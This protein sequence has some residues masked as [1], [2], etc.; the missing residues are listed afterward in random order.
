[1]R[2][3][4][5]SRVLFNRCHHPPQRSSSI[6]TSTFPIPF[7]FNRDDPAPDD[8]TLDKLIPPLLFSRCTVLLTLT[9]ISLQSCVARSL[10]IPARGLSPPAAHPHP[11]IHPP[12][13]APSNS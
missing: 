2:H 5:I 12:P 3:Y 13:I 4:P 11:P 10:S 6:P 7:P 9:F 1:M 8:T